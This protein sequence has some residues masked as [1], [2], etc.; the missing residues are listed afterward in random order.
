ML[1]LSVITRVTIFS[2]SLKCQFCY[3][4]SISVSNAYSSKF[5]KS[6][7]AAHHRD[8]GFEVAVQL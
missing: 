4:P 8:N 7:E 1:D 6:L 2:S 5:I 3:V